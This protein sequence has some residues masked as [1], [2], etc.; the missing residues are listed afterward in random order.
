MNELEKLVEWG[1]GKLYEF[2]EGKCPEGKC[3]E[4]C[5]EE[6]SECG[7][8]WHRYLLTNPDHPLYVKVEKE[9]PE[10]DRDWQKSCLTDRMELSRKAYYAAM[11]L[12]YS[13]AQ[14]SMLRHEKE[15]YIPLSEVKEK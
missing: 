10:I 1:E 4:D 9:L 8:C 2:A 15:S 11:D 6:D 13:C 5:S 3:F 14:K 12:N 7:K